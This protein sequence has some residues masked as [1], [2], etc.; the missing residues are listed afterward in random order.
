VEWHFCFQLLSMLFVSVLLSLLFSLSSS[1]HGI[2]I[3]FHPFPL[4]YIHT[5]TP[6][7]TSPHHGW[8]HSTSPVSR[9]GFYDAIN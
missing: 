9:H 2:C 8:L 5:Y 4:T 7:Y 6:T 1:S 3:H